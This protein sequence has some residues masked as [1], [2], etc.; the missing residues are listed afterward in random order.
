ML[1]LYQVQ[2]K[3]T[4]NMMSFLQFGDQ[5]PI[6]TRVVSIPKGELRMINIDPHHQQKKDL[7]PVP[8][9]QEGSCGFIPTLWEANSGLLLPTG[10]L[11]QSKSFTFQCGVCLFREAETDIPSLTDS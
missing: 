1:K 4:A 10:S 3:V 2:K 6:P 7:V 5:P 8:T 11:K 9:P